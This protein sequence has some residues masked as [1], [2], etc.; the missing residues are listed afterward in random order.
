MV[1]KQIPL[2]PKECYNCNKIICFLCELKCTYQDGTRIAN[3][4][5]YNCKVIECQKI[6]EDEFT[7]SNK[8]I[9]KDTKKGPGE[10]IQRPIYQ[11]IKNKLLNQMIGQIKVLHKCNENQIQ[12]C[13]YLEDLEKHIENKCQGF[14][15]E[16]FAC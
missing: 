5:C 3:K 4:E 7:K 14:E 8:M 12:Q 16:C 1:C 15:V 2:K 6:I 10:M 9:I 11:V 13:V